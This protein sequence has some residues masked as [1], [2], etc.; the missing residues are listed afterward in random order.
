MRQGSWS[1]GGYGASDTRSRYDKNG[2]SSLRICSDPRVYACSFSTFFRELIALNYCIEVKCVVNLLKVIH[3]ATVRFH[4]IVCQPTN[5][6]MLEERTSKPKL[7]HLP[8]SRNF[9]KL[10]HHLSSILRSV[11]Y[12]KDHGRICI[13]SFEIL[14][15]KIK[16]EGMEE[17]WI[18]ICFVFFLFIIFIFKSVC[19]R[20]WFL[21]GD[22]RW[23]FHLD[24][25]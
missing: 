21:H 18:G 3:I 17:C 1:I 13:W 20:T 12:G 16:S 11:V 10:I 24:D 8:R 4:F 19:R 22:L 14:K 25:I 5:W 2:N 23:K 15:N 7:A 9:E 6:S